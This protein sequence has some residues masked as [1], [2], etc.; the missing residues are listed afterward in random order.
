LRCA[1]TTSSRS[2]HPETRPVPM[3]LEKTLLR[4]CFCQVYVARG[5]QQE[6][7]DLRPMLL[8]HARKLLRGGVFCR[9]YGHCV[10]CSAGCHHPSRRRTKQSLQRN[11]EFSR[12][13][14]LIGPRSARRRTLVIIDRLFRSVCVILVMG[15]PNCRATKDHEFEAKLYRFRTCTAFFSSICATGNQVV[16]ED[17]RARHSRINIDASSVAPPVKMSCRWR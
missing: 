10:Q 8:N 5:R 6:T 4:Q 11:P 15:S 3:R 9:G 1:S 12:L 13:A 7:K 16:L 14:S 2:I 17:L